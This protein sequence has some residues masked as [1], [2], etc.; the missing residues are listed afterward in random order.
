MAGQPT[1]RYK[2]L[3]YEGLIHHWFPLIRGRLIS[4]DTCQEPGRVTTGNPLSPLPPF[5]SCSEETGEVRCVDKLR[6]LGFRF[7]EVV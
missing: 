1:R 5:E 4:H 2:A 6:G 7:I 3:P